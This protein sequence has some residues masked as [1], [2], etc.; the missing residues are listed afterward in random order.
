LCF[1]IVV[2]IELK[3]YLR[4]FLDIQLQHEML[5]ARHTY[6]LSDN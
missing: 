2:F 6:T 5:C 1:I 4:A 3:N